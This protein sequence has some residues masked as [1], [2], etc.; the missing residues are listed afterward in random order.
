[1]SKGRLF[2]TSRVLSIKINSEIF[3]RKCSKALFWVERYF[4]NFHPEIGNFENF[5]I[6]TF[7]LQVFMCLFLVIQESTFTYTK[8]VV[9][10]WYS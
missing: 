6:S 7:L 9:P 10:W 1:M 4:K 5:E 8:I 3:F 2:Y